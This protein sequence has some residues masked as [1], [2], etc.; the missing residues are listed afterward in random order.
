MARFE[1]IPPVKGSVL[2]IQTKRLILSVYKPSAAQPVTDYIV[3]N[4]KFHKPFQQRHGERY[5]TVSEQRSYLKSDLSMFNRNTQVAF[6]ITLPEEPERIIGRL[7]FYS[8]IGGA[9]NSCFV[10]YHLDELCQGQGYMSEALLAGC[11]FMFKFYRLHRIEAD[12]LPTNERSLA[13]AGRCG[14]VKMGYNEKF[15]EIDGEYRDHV[16]MVRLN[17]EVE[18]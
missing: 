10:G 8:L 1:I 12:I 7:S 11:D 14:F 4:R 3:R 6:W 2:S 13:C 17:P 15:M 9:M 16:M 18:M 5:Y